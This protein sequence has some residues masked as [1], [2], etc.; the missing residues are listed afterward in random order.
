MRCTRQKMIAALSVF[1][2]AACLTVV[3][4]VL[5]LRR[6]SVWQALL[7]VAAAGS[8]SCALRLLREDMAAEAA[9]GELFA[10]DE[11]E[12]AARRM[13]ESLGG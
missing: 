5:A 4:T 9:D 8:A 10:D 11:A 7:A 6:R 1:A 3:F 12:E 2:A 13:R